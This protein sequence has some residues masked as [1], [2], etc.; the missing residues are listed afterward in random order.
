MKDEQDLTI[1]FDAQ[2]LFKYKWKPFLTPV[3]STTD[4]ERH[5]VKSHESV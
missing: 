4:Y 2:K 3:I 1:A 5:K